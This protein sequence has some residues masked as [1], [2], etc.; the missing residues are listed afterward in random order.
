[1][2]GSQTDSRE[3]DR[4]AIATILQ[5]DATLQASLK[6][7][8][9]YTKDGIARWFEEQAQK[10]DNQRLELM[11]RSR[12]T[13]RRGRAQLQPQLIP[14]PDAFAPTSGASPLASGA[15]PKKTAKVALSRARPRT[16]RAG[17]CPRY[18]R[19][20]RHTVTGG[21][22]TTGSSRRRKSKESE[23]E[24]LGVEAASG[25]GLLIAVF[26]LGRRGQHSYGYVMLPL[27]MGALGFV[28]TGVAQGAVMLTGASAPGAVG[29]TP[30]TT[31]ENLTPQAGGFIDEAYAFGVGNFIPA[32]PGPSDPVAHN[33]WVAL[34]ESDAAQGDTL[35]L[36]WQAQN[37]PITAAF[38][39]RLNSKPYYAIYF[40]AEQQYRNIPLDGSPTS[41]SELAPVAHGIGTALLDTYDQV[42]AVAVAD[43]HNPASFV[44]LYGFSPEPNNFDPPE[45]LCKTLVE[46]KDG[47]NLDTLELALTVID[48][49]L[50]QGLSDTFSWVNGG[51]PLGGGGHSDQFYARLFPDGKA[52]D[53][54]AYLADLKL[55]DTIRKTFTGSLADDFKTVFKIDLSQP[56]SAT[57]AKFLFG[58]VGDPNFDINALLASVPIRAQIIRTIW[59]VDIGG[60]QWSSPRA[61]RP[62]ICRR[63]R[64]RQ[65]RGCGSALLLGQHDR[66]HRNLSRRHS[67][68]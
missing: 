41:F 5:R 22:S 37:D 63:L 53:P 31:L 60:V 58:L 12:E 3:E 40:H 17:R 51:L 56:L 42:N 46:E 25:A 65:H 67:E 1:M 16:A 66:P 28:A 19:R 36:K 18:S 43:K 62:A 14:T 11:A 7:Q 50:A 54:T 48:G 4:T 9:L 64:P 61:L 39:V 29:A 33:N 30:A 55:L 20:A 23:V 21:P 47:V 2:H 15:K 8:S 26:A 13:D 68:R 57:D 27:G 49:V 45:E 35:I 52:L 38:I 59:N 32:D 44:A 34:I 24:L 10:A 6:R